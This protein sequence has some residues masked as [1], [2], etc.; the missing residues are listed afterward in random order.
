M[1][2]QVLYMKAA[3]VTAK[4]QFRNVR[5]TIE[6]EQLSTPREGQQA[7][8]SQLRVIGS[9]KLENRQLWILRMM[10]GDKLDRKARLVLREKNEVEAPLWRMFCPDFEDKIEIEKCGPDEEGWNETILSNFW[11][12]SEAALNVALPEGKGHLGALGDPNATGIPRV[13]AHLVV[14]K[15]KRKKKAHAPVTLPP[16]VP[17]AAGT[18]RPRLHKYEDYMVVSDT[19][20]GLSVPGGSSGAGGA[21]VGTK[22]VD[23]KKHKGDASVT[24]GRKR[25]SFGRLGRLRFQSK[26]LRSLLVRPLE[27][28]VSVST[29][30]A[31]PPKVVEVEAQKKGGENPSI[32]VVSSEGTPPAVHTEQG[33]KKIGGDTLD[34]SNKL[35]DPRGEGDKG[36][37][38]PKSPI[39]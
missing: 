26:S 25:L 24:D 1:E 18:F 23:D 28:P 37:E 3:A 35:I 13:T 27:E 17:E 19:H 29:I 9:K 6:T 34:S 20:E 32:E 36:G 4:L 33:S 21:T 31:S 30:P 7:C 10:L 11:V 38:K 16:L 39:F 15:Q 12:P 14:D 22:P 2:E 8:F 5:G